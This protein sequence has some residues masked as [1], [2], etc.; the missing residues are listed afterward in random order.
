[1]VTFLE[2]I[3]ERAKKLNKTIAL[4]E[5]EDIRTLQAAAKVL[6]R[7]IANVVLIGK[8]KDIKELSGD[9][10]L[11]KARIVDPETY[12]RKDEY[13]KT[14][15]ELRK[16][17][18][19]TLDSAAEIMKDY[20]YFAVMM[21]KLGEVDGV[22]SGAVHS[23][24]DTL[25]PAVQIVKTAPDSA[26]ASAFFIISVPDCEYGSNG[27]FLFADSGMVEMP[28]VEELAHIAVTSAK[29]FELLVQDTPYVAMLSY[30]TKG[31]AHSKLTEATVAATKRAQELAP[32]IAIDGELQVDAAIVPKVAASKA[33]GSPVAGK[34][35]VLI[36]PDLNAGNIAYKIAH[37]LAKAEAYGPITQGLA[38]PINDL[39]RGCS[40]E[41]IVGAVAI[42]CV[43]AA[44]QQK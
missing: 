20:V 15:Y 6:E 8:E 36:F 29:T 12:E 5:T 4:P 7:G 35:N 14:F 18:G 19:V 42:T 43:Q 30:S 10:D 3:S 28:T 33:P 21:A 22:V 2:K 38:K 11:S 26:L 40:D 17:K 1:M 41:D 34:A 39:S 37:R 25:R 31:S 44:A 9:L 24:S 32:D 13:V 16:H 23:S 27:T